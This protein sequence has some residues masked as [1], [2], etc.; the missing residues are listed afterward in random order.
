MAA[1]YR[2]PLA[3]RPDEDLRQAILRADPSA[4]V[5]LSFGQLLSVEAPN[6]PQAALDALL[7]QKGVL[8]TTET[9]P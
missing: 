2:K 9:K 8:T 6:L 1:S 7:T 5:E 3:S 4:V